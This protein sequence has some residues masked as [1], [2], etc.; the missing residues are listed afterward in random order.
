ME[1]YCSSGELGS[2]ITT[3]WELLTIGDRIKENPG[4]IIPLKRGAYE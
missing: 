2:Q 1:L 4:E 3:L